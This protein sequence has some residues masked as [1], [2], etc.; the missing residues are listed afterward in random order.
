VTGLNAYL[1]ERK[2]D[3]GHS[4]GAG[5]NTDEGAE[6]AFGKSR[7]RSSGTGFCDPSVEGDAQRMVNGRGISEE[8]SMVANA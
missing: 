6:F 5:E 8:N 4:Q 7:N 1:R 2:E 3:F